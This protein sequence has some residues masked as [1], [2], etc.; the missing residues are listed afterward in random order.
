MFSGL[1]E[2]VRSRLINIVG[3]PKCQE[4]FVR[5]AVFVEPG[6]VEWREAPDLK[7]QGPRQA[8]V[9]PLVVGR[10]DLDVAY[11]RGLM[12]MPA[13]APIGHEIIGEVV[14]LGEET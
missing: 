12:P 5:H 6:R 10:C 14:A 1:N 9:R 3:N 13:G 7:L 11:V 4:G 2:A 8:L